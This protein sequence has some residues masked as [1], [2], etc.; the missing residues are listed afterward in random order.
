VETLDSTS[1]AGA[2]KRLS[3][4]FFFL[5][6]SAAGAA[7]A[8]AAAP[9]KAQAAP[10]LAAP[11]VGDV[12]ATL[13]ILSC[14]AVGIVSAIYFTLL[15]QKSVV[16]GSNENAS[17]V[18]EDGGDSDA[19][20]KTVWETSDAI[21]T[22]A[23]SFLYAEYK[24]L[25]I[26]IV[27]FSILLWV[28]LGIVSGVVNGLLSAV[29][30]ILG[31]VTSIVS[32]YIGMK[33]GVYANARTA[34]CAQ[35]GYAPAFDVAYKAGSVLGF[36]L[37]SLGV[38]VLF[39]TI[40]LFKFH[41]GHADE[42]LLYETVAGYGLGGSSVAL[43]GRVGGGIYTKAADV[44]SDLVGKVVMGIPEDD[45]RN[46]GVIADN[47]GDNVGDI[48]GMGADL[49]GS[50]A[51]STCAALV[52]AAQSPELIASWTAMMFPL[53]ISASGIITSLLTTFVVTHIKSVTTEEEIEPA[54]KR[55]LL[56]SALL[57]T[58]VV[59]LLC[60]YCLPAT[61]N[62]P[63]RTG[64]KNWY[65][66]FCVGSGLWSGLLIGYVTEYFTSHQY[67][68]VRDVAE[69]CKTGAATNIIYGLAL[70]YKSVIIPVFALASTLSSSLS[71]V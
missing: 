59:F 21:A 67:S 13:I 17:L 33:I 26:F 62:V 38:L 29:S 5:T 53:L 51:E 4:L 57:Q 19:A 34:I 54:L 46:P 47:V 65:I 52:V 7:A 69:S 30:F 9:A 71:P 66:F 28:L 44:G 16:R 49:F 42:A 10:A 32:G 18:H 31:A 11:I 20:I 15:V 2:A 70:G 25:A 27:V 35:K 58:P 39:V 64:V 48:A 37:P 8:P 61:F 36:A 68:P 41:F 40:N 14:T 22:G 56:V 1:L 24:I 23:A 43:F 6:A 60:Y 3:I 55:Q 12:G 50:L 63:G 45:P